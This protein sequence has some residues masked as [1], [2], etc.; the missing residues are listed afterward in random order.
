MYTKSWLLG[1]DLFVRITAVAPDDTGEFIP[2][3]QENISLMGKLDSASMVIDTV[4]EEISP[5][6]ARKYNHVAI[7]E[8]SSLEL[9]EILDKSDDPQRGGNILAACARS[10]HPGAHARVVITRGNKS[11]TFIGLIQHYEETYER[12]K[13]VGVMRLQVIDD[14]ANPNPMYA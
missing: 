4:S 8:D 5:M 10:A 12:G 6:V 2:V 7:A 14:S 9:R 13:N 11:W 3:G 1:R